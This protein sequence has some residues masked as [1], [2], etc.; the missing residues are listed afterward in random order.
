[1]PSTYY[2]NTRER[3]RKHQRLSKE[4]DLLRKRRY[5]QMTH[6]PAG[7]GRSVAERG[8]KKWEKHTN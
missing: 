8:N 3:E 4:G 6:V 2:D 5:I 1:M 7:V